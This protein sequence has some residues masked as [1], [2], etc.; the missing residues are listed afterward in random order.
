[1]TT[2]RDYQSHLLSIACV[3][4]IL[5]CP[6]FTGCEKESQAIV[7]IALHPANGEIVDGIEDRIAWLSETDRSDDLPI[8][9]EFQHSRML[10]VVIRAANSDI[11]RTL[12]VGGHGEDPAGCDRVFNSGPLSFELTLAVE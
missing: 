12:S 5:L 4:A 7:S 10:S 1:M 2:R 9:I 3:V 8:A 11:E 6:V